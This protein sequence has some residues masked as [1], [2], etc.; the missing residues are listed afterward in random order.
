[1]NEPPKPVF[2]KRKKGPVVPKKPSAPPPAPV[3]PPENE[4][5]REKRHRTLKGAMII[6]PGQMMCSF[7]CRVRNES[8][9]GV[10]LVLDNGVTVPDEFYLMRDGDPGKRIPCQVRW[11]RMN[12]VGVQFVDRLTC[13]PD[14]P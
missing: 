14:G 12:A 3:F 8:S 6:L 2:G 4:S 1:M 5:R 13:D 7:A 9:G 11:R 10:M